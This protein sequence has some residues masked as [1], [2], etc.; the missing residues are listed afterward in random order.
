M[1]SNS[2]QLDRYDRQLRIWGSIGQDM[3]KKAHICI[4]GS[5]NTLIHETFKNL[6]LLGIS[7]FTWFSQDNIPEEEDIYNYRTDVKTEITG[8]CLGE[9]NFTELKSNQELHDYS[10]F[11][12]IIMLNIQKELNLKSKSDCNLPPIINVKTSGFYGYVKLELSEPHMVLDPHNEYSK[13]DLRLDQLWDEFEK[14]FGVYNTTDM[15]IDDSIDYPYPVLLNRVLKH[16]RSG[17]FSTEDIKKNL[18]E[19]HGKTRPS[20]GFDRLNYLE[21]LRYA[22]RASVKS[23]HDEFI[24]LLNK[25]IV[26]YVTQ[27]CHKNFKRWSDPMNEQLSDLIQQLTA[28]VNENGLELPLQGKFP[29]MECD[30][31]EYQKL[32]E[33]Y[34]RHRSN[35]VN[36]FLQ[37][38]LLRENPFNRNIVDLFFRSL[39]DLTIIKPMEDGVTPQESKLYNILSNIDFFDDA[40][41]QHEE[42]KSISKPA[43]FPIDVFVAGLAS[44]EAIKLITHQFVPINNT[45]VYDGLKGE[46]T[47]TLRT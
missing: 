14:Y 34:D 47:E 21:A 39:M 44:Q 7:N 1:I 8:L 45:F 41:R 2:V 33:I 35:Y 20:K 28:F 23:E 22:S 13:V 16:F 27:Q 36:A 18:R 10:H 5:N 15:D 17:D 30:H 31:N 24:E 37:R 3:L 42:F 38:Q 6:V 40:T 43:L 32:K 46:H 25:D 29:D 12:L 19:M 26:P 9:L 4:I 11:D